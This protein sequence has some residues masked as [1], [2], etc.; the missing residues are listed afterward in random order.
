MKLLTIVLS[1]FAIKWKRLIKKLVFQH[2]ISTPQ[3]FTSWN[4]FLHPS[5]LLLGLSCNILLLLTL[6]STCFDATN[7]IRTWEKRFPA[8][9]IW[10]VFHQIDCHHNKILLKNRTLGIFNNVFILVASSTEIFLAI[11]GNI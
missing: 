8:F 4:Q 5:R 6:Q 11:F 3:I 7:F 2:L 1:V 9:P 10:L